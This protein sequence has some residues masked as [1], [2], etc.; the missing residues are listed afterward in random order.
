MAVKENQDSPLVTEQEDN[1]DSDTEDLGFYTNS[2]SLS[3]A[4]Q[5]IL[6]RSERRKQRTLREHHD[7]LEEVSKNKQA[8]WGKNPQLSI[9]P[10]R[11][12][13]NTELNTSSFLT[14]EHPE[15]LCE[16]S[17]KSASSHN[18]PSSLAE[19]D[20]VAH[21]YHRTCKSNKQV[22]DNKSSSKDLAA[23][24]HTP[25]RTGTAPRPK[26]RKP[27]LA[28]RSYPATPKLP[29]SS[30]STK[31]HTVSSSPGKQRNVSAPSQAT[32]NKRQVA[33]DVSFGKT[34]TA[35]STVKSQRPL[36]SAPNQLSKTPTERG[37]RSK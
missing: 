19:T 14:N 6:E 4:S 12:G 20:P 32:V 18:G 25:C 34:Q 36:K 1:S 13:S 26:E 15:L 27:A 29:I 2:G 37:V 35:T 21:Q 23:S 10:E 9:L 11:N 30:T 7:R 28:N 3:A 16:K 33:S 5:D 31:L 24:L 17:L 22:L 8:L